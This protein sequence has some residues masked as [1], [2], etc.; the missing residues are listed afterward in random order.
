VAADRLGGGAWAVLLA[1]FVLVSGW[2]ELVGP[3]PGD[4]RILTAVHDVSGPRVED[5]GATV[6]DLTDLPWLVAVAALVVG[7]LLLA[8]R[9]ADAAWFLVA[10]GVVWIV[11]PMLKELFARGRPDLWPITE[12][13]SLYGFPSGH[14]ANTAALAAALAMLAWRTRWRLPVVVGGTLLVVLVGLTQLTLGVHYPSDV[15]AGWL[16]AAA[17]VAFVASRRPTAR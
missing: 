6:G 16:W 1:G 13:V 10:V 14:A 3:P 11:N 8:R 15:L 5:L 2:L 12:R 17:W 7:A 4:R 9:R